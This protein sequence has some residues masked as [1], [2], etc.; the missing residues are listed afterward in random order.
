MAE[1]NKPVSLDANISDTAFNKKKSPQKEEK[2]SKLLPY[3]LGALVLLAG[4]Y[5]ISSSGGS[6]I[7]M[8]LTPEQEQVQTEITG[9][10]ESYV[11]EN[12]SFP[13]DP[14]ELNLPEG[15]EI[16]MGN[17]GSWIVS[18]ADSQL[19]LSENALA[20]FEDG[21]QGPASP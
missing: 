16:I 17:D 9:I 4:Y 12:G 21:P 1:A 2:D 20:P 10:V 8:E 5:L 6:S 13:D 14:A 7:Q 19:I 18:T 11:S 3:L 15:S